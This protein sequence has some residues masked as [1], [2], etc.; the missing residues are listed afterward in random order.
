MIHKIDRVWD[1][2][3]HNAFTDLIE[4]R[5]KF[6]LCFR[7]GKAHTGAKGNGTIRILQ[8]GD[9]NHWTT[10]AVLKKSGIDLRDPH[11]SITPRNQ[12][13]LTLG[14]S[15]YKKGKYEGCIPQ[16]SFSSDGLHWSTVEEIPLPNEW[17]WRITWHKRYGYGFSYRLSDPLKKEKPWILTLFK[18]TDGLKYTPIKKFHMRSHPS[19]ATLRFLEDGT[20]VA[21]LRRR[22]P[23]WIGTSKDGTSKGGTSKDG[24]SK[25]KYTDWKW[26]SCGHLIGGPNFLILPDGQMIAGGR[27]FKKKASESKGYTHGKMALGPMTLKSYHP[28]T[29]LLSAKDSGYPG[30]VYRDET[31]YVSY[32]SS[33]EKKAS[34]YFA[35]II[36]QE[37]AKDRALAKKAKRD[38]H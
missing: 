23:A 37:C 30:M 31:L 29:I 16:V 17:I 13:M 11:F 28:Q 19:E 8:S 20:M 2:S 34:I 15:I 33:H 36:L 9:G 14:G 10:A 3:G 26:T 4:F 5:G 35:K 38:I 12:L 6:F 24:T 21:L 27:D 18:T 1:A 22:G 7:E 25:G 32:Y